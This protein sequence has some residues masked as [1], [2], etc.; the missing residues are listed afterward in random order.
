M[1]LSGDADIFLIDASAFEAMTT[2]VAT[3]E[4]AVADLIA[5][6]PRGDNLVDLTDMLDN[7]LGGSA[8]AVAPASVPADTAVSSLADSV[9]LTGLTGVGNT[10]TI[11]YDDGATAVL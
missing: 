4:V 10:I 8:Q 9:E 3:P 5:D 2:V 11:L 7:V 1:L 6:Y